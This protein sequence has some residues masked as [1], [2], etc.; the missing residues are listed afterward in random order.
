[1]EIHKI[2]PPPTP[3]VKGLI[4]ILEVNAP[5]GPI[6]NCQNAPAYKLFTFI[7]QVN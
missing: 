4:K 7:K 2:T 1:M 6:V 3:T 5:V